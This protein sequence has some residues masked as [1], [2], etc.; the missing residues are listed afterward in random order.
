[1]QG[2][3]C[4]F[5]TKERV[6]KQS[7]LSYPHDYYTNHYVV[8]QREGV[9]QTWFVEGYIENSHDGIE[10]EMSVGAII[11]DNSGNTFKVFDVTD[12]KFI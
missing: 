1:M 4:T 3:R 12:I 9:F 10:G 5:I 8:T 7:T 2:S 6:R 11:V